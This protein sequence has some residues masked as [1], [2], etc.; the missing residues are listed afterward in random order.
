MKSDFVQSIPSPM[1][2]LL[3]DE[4]LAAYLHCSL[5]FVR[6]LATE[7][8]VAYLPD[9]RHRRYRVGDVLAYL[10]KECKASL[11]SKR[12]A[13]RQRRR[14]AGARRSTPSGVQRKL[15]LVS[16]ASPLPSVEEALDDPAV[17]SNPS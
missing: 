16:A 13:P 3:D 14:H 11:E 12:R 9:G 8:R 6:R 1:P 15:L 17:P 2:V 5:R 10:D 7:R 4:Q